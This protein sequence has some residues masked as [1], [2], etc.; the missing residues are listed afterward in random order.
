MNQARPA[1]QS[2]RK[3]TAAP[4]RAVGTGVGTCTCTHELVVRLKCHAKVPSVSRPV[5]GSTPKSATAVVSFMRVTKSSGTAQLA[6]CVRVKTAADAGCCVGSCVAALTVRSPGTDAS[7]SPERPPDR[8]RLVEL[9]AIAE[10]T[11][12]TGGEGGTLRTQTGVCA[13]D[14][15]WKA[16]PSSRTSA[17]EKRSDPR[18]M[19]CFS[20]PE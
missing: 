12:P 15:A 7:V 2:F 19:T 11:R 6:A 16:A 3:E 20:D 10:P 1:R 14:T 13:T 5:A 8:I 18:T 9:Y 17:S 4:R